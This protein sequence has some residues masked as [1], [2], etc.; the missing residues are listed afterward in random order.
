[1]CFFLSLHTVGKT[2]PTFSAYFPSQNIKVQRQL[3]SFFFVPSLLPKDGQE[4]VWW[5]VQADQ[6][7][8][9]GPFFREGCKSSSTWKWLPHSVETCSRQWHDATWPSKPH[10]LIN[11]AVN[12]VDILFCV[13]DSYALHFNWFQTISRKKNVLIG[14]SKPYQLTKVCFSPLF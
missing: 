7:S 2:Y 12:Q 13:C 14:I 8:L 9:R 11:C 4:L 6:G 5:L 1:M 10:S 3:F